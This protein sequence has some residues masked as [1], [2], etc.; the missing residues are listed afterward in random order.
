VSDSAESI[1]VPVPARPRRRDHTRDLVVAA[2]LCALLA[3]LAWLRIPLPFT[4]VPLTLQV[5]VVCLVALLLPPAEI[6]LC[7]GGYLLLG[8]AGVPVFSGGTGGLGVLIG[9]T[10][11]YLVGFF[12][13]AFVG[14]SARSG[15][16]KLGSN[17]L[18]A[19]V[20]AVTLT[21]V[22]IYGFGWAQLILVT[23]MSPGAAFVAGVAP[24]LLGDVVK[25]AA[26]IAVANA[27]RRTGL[28]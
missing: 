2:L 28:V 27:L 4:P 3:A 5:F 12:V 9:P 24:F 17:R 20:V 21:I 1:P 26:A 19:D 15:M 16:V 23:G 18:L 22:G 14:G 13:G 6:A 10:G 7:L 11:G 8:A 25:A